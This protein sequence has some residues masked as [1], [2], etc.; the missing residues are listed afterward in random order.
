MKISIRRQWN[1]YQVAEVDFDNLESLHWD[2]LSGGVSR[3]AP[4]YFIHGN[5][6]CNLIEGD[7]AH[8]CVHGEGPHNIKICITKKDNNSETCKRLLEIVGPKPKTS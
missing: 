7:I 4:Q 3:L 1:D 2:R 8:S 5:V 6:L